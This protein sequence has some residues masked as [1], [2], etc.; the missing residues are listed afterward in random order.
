MWRQIQLA[1]GLRFEVELVRK[2]QGC[3]ARAFGPLRD[4][5][6]PAECAAEA[7]GSSFDAA[8]AALRKVLRKLFR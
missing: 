8:E 4:G 7:A 6:K 2:E 3:A 1:S 5:E